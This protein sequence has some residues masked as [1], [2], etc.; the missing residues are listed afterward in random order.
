MYFIGKDNTSAIYKLRNLEEHDKTV[1]FR[2]PLKLKPVLNYTLICMA[3]GKLLKY[4]LFSKVELYQNWAHFKHLAPHLPRP[5]SSCGLI[6]LLF[7]TKEFV[8]RRLFRMSN[9]SE[10]PVASF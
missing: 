5:S 6:S 10:D 8:G 4:I 2:I 3:L 7:G 1:R 9:S